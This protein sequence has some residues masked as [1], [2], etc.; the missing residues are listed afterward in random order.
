MSSNAAVSRA[1]QPGQHAGAVSSSVEARFHEFEVIRATERRR[2]FHAV[3]ALGGR[4]VVL[5]AAICLLT[6]VLPFEEGLAQS[7]MYSTGLFGLQASKIMLSTCPL[8]FVS[9]DEVFSSQPR[10]RIALGIILSAMFVLGG[11]LK[12]PHLEMAVAAFPLLMVCSNAHTQG[13]RWPRCTAL[14]DAMWC[15]HRGADTA[16]HAHAAMD[17]TGHEGRMSFWVTLPPDAWWAQGVLCAVSLIFLVAIWAFHRCHSCGLCRGSSAP[18]TMVTF[19]LMYAFDVSIGLLLCART[20]FAALYDPGMTPQTLAS[21]CAFL[22][23]T[24]TVLLVGRNRLFQTVARHLDTSSERAEQDGAFVAELLDSDEVKPGQAWWVH[25]GEGEKDLWYESHQRR[26]NWKFGRVVQVLQDELIVEVRLPPQAAQVPEVQDTSNLT[27]SQNFHRSS[28]SSSSYSSRSRLRVSSFTALTKASTF[29]S[30]SRLGKRVL[31]QVPLPMRNMK[32]DDLLSQARSSLRCVDWSNISMALITG[33]P[34]CT[35]R[36]QTVNDDLYQLSRSVARGETTDFFVSHSWHDDGKRRFDALEQLATSFRCS[37]QRDPTFWLDKVC[38]D[39]CNL[40]DGLKVLPI[41]VMSCR[42]MLVLCGETYPRRLWCAWELCT[43]MAFSGLEQALKRVKLVSV[44]RFP[45]NA[46]RQLAQF[47]V[48]RASCYDPNEE[49]RLMRVIEALGKHRFNK[50]IRALGGAQRRLQAG[51][52][53]QLLMSLS[54]LPVFKTFSSNETA[55]TQSTPSSMDTV[56]SQASTLTDI[57]MPMAASAME[58]PVGLQSADL[59]LT[60]TEG[61]R[62]HAVKAT[63]SKVGANLAPAC[64]SSVAHFDSQPSTSSALAHEEVLPPINASR[65]P[66]WPSPAPLMCTPRS[67]LG[68]APSAVFFA[69]QSKGSA[70]AARSVW[71]SLPLFCCVAPPALLEHSGPRASGLSGAGAE[72]RCPARGSTNGGT[73]APPCVLGCLAAGVT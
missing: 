8:D 22:M 64:A 66:A 46:S 13:S 45:A 7:V 51:L 21:A 68:P 53:N 60:E 3:L 38:I 55:S 63:A 25:L 16:A 37:H 14:L 65:G 41:I 54:T 5:C 39:Q 67:R 32:V 12:P 10:L 19:Q 1:A 35:S 20:A 47:D 30:F 11:F 36:G 6:L 57:A 62:S 28:S 50:S 52:V 18:R 34:I 48:S 42:R 71:S 49:A 70:V 24:L 61:P 26:H 17:P 31:V 29:T 43:L 56:S 2:E 69:R 72:Q 59:E 58:E 27:S 23:P 33:G 15:A 44:H 40:A 73:G 4:M 9:I